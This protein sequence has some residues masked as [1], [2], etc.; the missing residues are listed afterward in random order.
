MSLYL[1]ILFSKNSP[2]FW[3]TLYVCRQVSE[4]D[5]RVQCRDEGLSPTADSRRQRS[6]LS[7]TPMSMRS[8]SHRKPGPYRK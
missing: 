8:V 2:G 5:S 3:P 1:D 6:L 7:V 4:Q